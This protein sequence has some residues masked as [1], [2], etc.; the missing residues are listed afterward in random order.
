[1]DSHFRFSGFMRT[2]KIRRHIRVSLCG[3]Q[4]Y[5]Y[6]KHQNLL[7]WQLA[8][9]SHQ[10][11]CQISHKSKEMNPQEHQSNNNRKTTTFETPHTMTWYQFF[12][13]FR[14][15]IADKGTAVT[16]RGGST[17]QRTQGP[18]QRAAST[19]ANQA[20][21]V[22]KNEKPMETWDYFMFDVSDWKTLGLYIPLDNLLIRFFSLVSNL[23]LLFVRN[24]EYGDPCVIPY[25]P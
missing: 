15:G 17:T 25:L 9:P 3:I 21:A 16:R 6:T 5:P 23:S 14:K 4:T 2:Q 18:T 20:K 12:V 19:Q 13:A 10:S 24:Q 1:M 22:G 11:Q 8:S 7:N